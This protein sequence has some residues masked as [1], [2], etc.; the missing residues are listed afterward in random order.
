MSTIKEMQEWT[1][2][3]L[4]DFCSLQKIKHYSGK[5]R[6]TKAQLLATIAE[7]YFHIIAE[8]KE[9]KGDEI[10]NA[11]NANEVNTDAADNIGQKMSYVEN[12][13]IGVLVAFKLSNGKVKSAKVAKKSSSKRKLLLETEYGKTYIVPYEDII[14]VRTGNRWPKGV[15]KLLKGLD[16]ENDGKEREQEVK[17]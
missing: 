8:G 11:V 5:K 1:T 10:R 4:S 17:A 12:I 2:A 14:W 13:K 3:E 16:D 7:N 9:N 6:F 15:Y